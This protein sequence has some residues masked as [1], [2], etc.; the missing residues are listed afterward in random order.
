M[1]LFPASIWTKHLYHNSLILLTS[2]F[3]SKLLILLTHASS[4][5][6]KCQAA[7]TLGMQLTSSQLTLMFTWIFNFIKFYFVSFILIPDYVGLSGHW[8][9]HQTVFPSF[10]T[11]LSM[12]HAFHVSSQVTNK[13]TK[14]GQGLP[15]PIFLQLEANLMWSYLKSY[16]S[17][18]HTDLPWTTLP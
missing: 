17:V 11:L 8:V 15:L 12:M 13:N 3:L 2:N 18:Y 14:Q 4:S 1:I 6:K 5:M 7:H 10:V 9:Y 16:E